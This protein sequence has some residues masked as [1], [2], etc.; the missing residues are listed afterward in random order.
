M[1]DKGFIVAKKSMK[2]IKIA[3]IRKMMENS[4]LE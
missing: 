4:L 3:I 1:I 2:K